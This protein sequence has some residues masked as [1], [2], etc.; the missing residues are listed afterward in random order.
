M[1]RGVTG[2]SAVVSGVLAMAGMCSTAAAASA[3][4]R[5]PSLSGQTLAF[6]AEG[7][8][9][10]ARL[11]DLQARRLTSTDG[12]EQTPFVS[13]DGKQVAFVAST[14]GP[15]EVYVMPATGGIPERVTFE[16]AQVRLRGWTHDGQLLYATTGGVGPSSQWQLRT[17]DPQSHV[18]HDI[19]LQDALNGA[20]ADDGRQLYFTRFG[21]NVTGDNARLYRGGAMGQLWHYD[22]QSQQEAQRLKTPGSVSA[23]MVYKQ[24]LIFLSDADGHP[25]LWRSALDGSHR[26]Q[27]THFADFPVQQ[28]TQNKGRVVFQHGA[29]IELLDLRDD[30]LRTLTPELSSDFR[31]RQTQWI[32]KPMDELEHLALSGNGRRAVVTA[33]GHVALLGTDAERLID[34]PTPGAARL[35]AAV[36]GP[37]GHWIYAISDATG[38]QE[39]WR[40]PADGS[41]QG[42]KALTHDGQGVRW[43]IHPSPDGRWLA[44]DDNQGRLWLLN[45]H[46]GQDRVI[47]KQ[48]MGG[49]ALGQD[50]H[51][52]AW[53]PNSR[54]LAFATQARHDARR[55]VVLYSVADDKQMTVTSDRYESYSPAFSGNGQWLYFLSNRHF[56]ATPAAPWGDRNLGPAFNHRGEIYALALTDKAHFPFAPPTELDPLG[57]KSQKTDDAKHAQTTSSAQNSSPRATAID[58]HQA[59][60]WSA[61]SSHLWQV[62]VPAGDYSALSVT[63]K[64]L[65]L[66]RNTPDN[67]SAPADDDST[68]HQQLVTIKLS[69]RDPDVQTFADNVQDYR[70][71]ADQKRL[72]LARGE[73]GHDLLI[74]KAGDKLADDDVADDTVRTADWAFSVNPMAQ[75]KEMFNDAWLMHRSAF[76]D[77]AMRGVDWAAVHKRYSQLLPRLADRRD[78]N[79]LLAQMKTE[80]SALHSQV[81]GGDVDKADNIQGAS[82]GARLV[83]TQQG[84]RIDHIY[85]TDPELP[86][87][88]APLAKPGVDARNGDTIVALNDRPVDDLAALYRGLRNQVD[89]QVLLTLAR[90][91]QQH[92][93]VVTPTDLHTDAHLRYRDWVEGNA[94]RVT[95]ASHGQ[96]GYLH[97]YAMGA[98]DI[99]QFVR[100][101]QAQYRKAGLIIDVRRNRGGNID[102][103]VINQLMRRSWMFWQAPKQGP[104]RNMQQ[105]FRGHM[106]VLTDALTYSD[107]E[108]FSAGIKALGIAPLIGQRTAG[109]G[110]WL[111]DSHTLADGGH[112]R[113]AE[114]PQF[115]ADGRW[116]V[117]GR[118]VSPDIAVVNKPHASFEGQ[119]AQLARGIDYLEKQLKQQPVTPFKP[120]SIPALKDAAS[121]ARPVKPLPPANSSARQ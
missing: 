50:A 78:L 8:I 74:V 52:I 55:R 2:L 39:I 112:A 61:L 117:E 41:G 118:G 32:D 26:K 29:D 45:T 33:R 16:Q 68:A 72:L 58:S 19:P 14:D 107:G 23:P 80:L 100:D 31:H 95:K 106:V 30:Q 88:A 98:D 114:F 9:W 111:S 21:L 91:G 63:D 38:V 96:I 69:R 109:A 40:Y 1:V 82:L 28:P 67:G 93:T 25:N 48:G 89:H 92:K 79:D 22:T 62:P 35:R 121:E 36:A 86:D 6:V 59:L 104:Q 76:F 101:F 99:A 70:L 71:S 20:F 65:F 49:Q 47:Y 108:T 12:A 4:Y 90:D 51:D 44:H 115:E 17:V 5:A 102:S 27:L 87:Q 84:I 103:W 56:E 113:I 46:T 7:D 73:K 77:P 11:G 105:S 75:W 116:L 34:I 53:S 10:L 24:Q 37:K 13:P 120:Q 97:L 15:E 60:D 94:A 54:Y 110:V 3:Y 64:R 43:S 85:R 66:L 42:A 81:R 18:T 83:Q 119:D 57:A